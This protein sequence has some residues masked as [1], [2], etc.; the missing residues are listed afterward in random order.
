[1]QEDAELDRLAYE[2]NALQ[3]Q[4]KQVQ[5]QMS[6]LQY[7]FGETEA[8][9]QALK[10]LGGVKEET[11]FPIGADTMVKVKIADKL[12]TARCFG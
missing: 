12:H 11:W 10:G 5:E 4:A 7:A 2:M 6:K 3:A 1:M 9:I 8:T